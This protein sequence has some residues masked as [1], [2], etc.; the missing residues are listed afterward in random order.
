MFAS[1]LICMKHYFQLHC[2]AVESEGWN[3]YRSTKW[4]EEF[5]ATDE[6]TGLR[7]TH[8]IKSSLKHVAE[9]IIQN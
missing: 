9:K 5:G 3:L 4:F 1:K 7:L 6:I 2:C 8:G